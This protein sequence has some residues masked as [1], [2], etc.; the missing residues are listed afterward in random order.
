MCSSCSAMFYNGLEEIN[1]M[2]GGKLIIP[3]N[4]KF[5][6]SM[7]YQFRKMTNYFYTNDDINLK[8]NNLE[9]NYSLFF[10]TL[11]WTL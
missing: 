11:L 3:T 10:I 7:G 1:S 9:L 8:S 5:S 6:L 2:A 4:T